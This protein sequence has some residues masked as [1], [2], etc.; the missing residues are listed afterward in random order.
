MAPVL[1]YYVKEWNRPRFVRFWVT[2]EYPVA[3]DEFN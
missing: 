1:K 2:D 3:D